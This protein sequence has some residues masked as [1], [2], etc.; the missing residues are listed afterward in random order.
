MFG[1][2]FNSNMS[3]IENKIFGDIE[4]IE[5]RVDE[6]PNTSKSLFQE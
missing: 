2:T 1:V 6:I 4:I 3:V 5:G